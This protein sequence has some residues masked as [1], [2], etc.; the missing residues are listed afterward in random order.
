MNGLY[1]PYV[2]PLYVIID[3]AL[4]DL[5]NVCIVPQGWQRRHIQSSVLET[6]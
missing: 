4:V 3:L 2:D 6:R 1:L 5:S